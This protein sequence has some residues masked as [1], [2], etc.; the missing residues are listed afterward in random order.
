MWGDVRSLMW[1]F[2]APTPPGSVGRST[3][4]GAPPGHAGFGGQSVHY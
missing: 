3:P 1:G 2:L 4:A